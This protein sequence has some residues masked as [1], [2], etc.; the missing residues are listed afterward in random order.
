MFSKR[1]FPT[2]WLT[3][4]FTTSASAQI[5]PECAEPN[6]LILFDVSGSM[7]KAA[8]GTKYTQAVDALSAAL[9]ALQ[10]DIRFGLLMFPAPDGQ[11][12]DLVTVPQVALGL[13]NAGAIFD[14]LDP[15]GAA[16]WGGPTASHDTPMYQALNAAGD[17]AELKT[18]ERRNYVIL[19]TDGKQDCCISGD[20]D[21][22]PDCLPAST[23]LDPVEAEQNIADLVATVSGLGADDIDTFV[24]GFG[25]GVDALS[26]NQMAK[27]GNTKKSPTCNDAETDPASPLNCYYS[28]ADGPA[29]QAALAA[30]ATVV[31]EESCDGIDNDCDGDVDEDWPDL[32]LSCDGDDKD[33]CADG[34]FVC[35]KTQ[36]SV[37]CSE[38]GAGN[39]EI[40][41]GIDNDCDGDIDEEHPQKGQS[42]DGFDAD[43]CKNG[44]YKCSDDGQNLGCVEDGDGFVETCNGLDDDCDGTLDEGDLCDPG[45]ECVGGS[46]VV[47]EDNPGDADAGMAPDAEDSPADAGPGQDAGDSPADDDTGGGTDVDAGT[48]PDGGITAPP[49]DDL[50]TRGG[51]ERTGGGDGS[52]DADDGGCGCRHAPAPS[53]VPVGPAALLVMMGLLL[54]GARRRG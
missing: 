36:T 33:V 47:V 54:L 27:A 10:G 25:D 15:G 6:I 35:A 53:S 22:D 48:S 42:C 46:C 49:S 26:L 24:I 8:P 30:I 14:I 9:P 4:A 7:G 38:Q 19:I 20:Y 39:P 50:G 40:C 29:I 17:L 43:Q 13:E 31:S 12:C 23:T 2:L 16:F 5:T 44:I 3:L 28:A 45:L 51:G 32:G 1:F 21:D 34:T 37:I 11:G 41:D 18:P 52:D